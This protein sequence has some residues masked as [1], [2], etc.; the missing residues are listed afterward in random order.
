MNLENKQFGA[1]Q[2]IRLLGRGGMA[3]VWLGRQL[4]LNR[5]VAL[6][7]I[8]DTA[9]E[10]Q[11]AERF[12]RE[13]QALARLDHPG[14][15]PVIDYGTGDGYLYLVM[16]FVAGGS[17]QHRLEE[18]SLSRGQIIEIFGWLLNGL[19]YAHKQGIIHRDL[20]PAN[21]LLHGDGRAVIADFGIAKDEHENVALTKVGFTMGSPEYMAPEQFM[22]EADYRSDLY[23]MGVM[24][25]QLLTRHVPYT[26]SSLWAIG[27]SHMKEPVPLPHPL[28]P[29]S[30]EGFLRKA[31]S[32]LPE[33]R[34]QTA[35]QMEETFREVVK[36]S[37]HTAVLQ[38]SNSFQQVVSLTATG[39]GETY[40]LAPAYGVQQDWP[41]EG[42]VSL[43][44]G[45]LPPLSPSQP[46][47]VPAPPP[48]P[49]R[50]A[51]TVSL[52]QEASPEGST[53]QR[54]KWLAAVVTLLTVVVCLAGLVMLTTS[55]GNNSKSASNSNLTASASTPTKDVTLPANNSGA[56]RPSLRIPLDPLNGTAVKGELVIVDNGNDTVSVTLTASE[57][58]PGLHSSHIHEGSCQAQGPIRFP[59]PDLEADET[60]KA[61]SSVILRVGFATLT[62]GKYYLNIHNQPGTPTYVSGCGEI[63]T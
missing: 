5:E 10:H 54:L 40:N 4:N 8:A 7:L 32:K 25:Y 43:G 6:K 9:N 3:E 28:V 20:K 39:R 38:T 17:L 18:A 62:N 41:E 44:L 31:L 42:T 30:L 12:A 56:D 47:A 19:K 50:E 29:P 23:S 51:G 53:R 34:F 61:I 46:V 1:Y 27:Q 35:A 26:G 58:A 15:L 14:I 59:L 11:L 2:L 22:G 49:P 36:P 24:L 63:N 52:P 16:P 48:E 21:I 13:A 55:P 45:V 37:S 60:G 33:E 57:L